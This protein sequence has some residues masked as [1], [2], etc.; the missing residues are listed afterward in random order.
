MPKRALTEME[1]KY[2]SISYAIQSRMI[3][4]GYSSNDMSQKIGMPYNTFRKRIKEPDSWRLSELLEVCKT[5]KLDRKDLE[6]Q[7]GAEL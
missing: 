5:L 3:F 6:P 2:K 7:K 1:K 4:Y